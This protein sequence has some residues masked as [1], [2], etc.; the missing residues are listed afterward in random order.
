[1][2]WRVGSLLTTASVVLLT[3]PLWIPVVS[4]LLLLI[5]PTSVVALAVV[6]VRL[7]WLSAEASASLIASTMRQLL[8]HA[9]QWLFGVDTAAWD[10][11]RDDDHW[12]TPIYTDN[13]GNDYFFDEF[14]QPR[15]T[16]SLRRVYSDLA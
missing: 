15:S 10:G 1:M 14:G 11:A 3:L 16:G 6:F 9:Y 12:K 7:T 8:A 2:T 4:V 5:L 13:D